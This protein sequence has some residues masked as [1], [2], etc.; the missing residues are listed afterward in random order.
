[1][2]LLQL[3]DDGEFSLV[4]YLG[5]NIPDYAILSHIWGPD[6]NEIEYQDILSR[7]GKEKL[8]I[9]RFASEQSK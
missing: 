3:Q 8:V 4:E 9:N 7:K 2:H 6:R 1:M 5:N